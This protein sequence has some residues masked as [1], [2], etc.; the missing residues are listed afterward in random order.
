MKELQNIQ[1]KILT[2]NLKHIVINNELKTPMLT[3]NLYFCSLIPENNNFMLFECFCESSCYL[4]AKLSDTVHYPFHY[5]YRFID[6][7]SKQT[8]HSVNFMFQYIL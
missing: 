7:D 4:L 2:G 6:F 8:S 1:K 3:E 5:I